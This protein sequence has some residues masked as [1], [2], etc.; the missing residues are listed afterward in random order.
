MF[1]DSFRCD[2]SASISPKFAITREQIQ[3]TPA[4][5]R[6][7]RAPGLHRAEQQRPTHLKPI[8]PIPL[9]QDRLGQSSPAA[10]AP[11][12]PCPAEP[13]PSSL[14]PPLSSSWRE[15]ANP[16]PHHG[17]DEVVRA[18]DEDLAGGSPALQGEV[19]HAEIGREGLGV[20]DQLAQGIGF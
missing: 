15:E 20:I 19:R 17:D 9:L 6:C 18:H 16:V 5:F 12:P 7:E 3:A 1:E 14:L 4:M 13:T 8:S 10:P 11:V 2:G